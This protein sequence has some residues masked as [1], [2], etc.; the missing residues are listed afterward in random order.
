MATWVDNVHK[1]A[2]VLHD[3]IAVALQVQRD[4]GV[5][6]AAFIA[7]QRALLDEL[8]E[9]NMPLAGLMDKSDI[10]F[11]AEGPG[12]QH[13]AAFSNA[14]AWLCEEV[15]RR[16]RQLAVASL[17]LVGRAADAA[18]QDLRV[19]LNGMAPGSLWAGFSV[20]SK[21]RMASFSASHHGSKVP[22]MAQ[23]GDDEV[24]PQ[25]PELSLAMS[26]ALESVRAAV[27]ALPSIPQF[28]GEE[29][30][31]EEINDA[32]TDPLV[33]DATLIAAF[34]LAPTGRRG[35]HTLEI[36]APRSNEAQSSLTNRERTVLRETTVRQ[37][38]LRATKWG[39]FTGQLREVD[40]DARRFQ[41]RGVPNV[42]TVRCVL[43]AMNVDI[44]RRHIGQ[45]AKVTGSYE[46]DREGRPRLM[47]VDTIE[48]FQI[49]QEL[50]E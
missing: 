44:A 30:V 20:D 33:R 43:D 17:G 10:L 32:F 5:D 28:I 49:Q 27:R 13:H 11:H 21:Q 9:D 23:D 29:R 41:L 25:L 38:M 15:E 42:G 22:P 40:L 48:P 18:E 26:D 34:H 39:T 46:A 8:Y 7:Q 1:R 36:S 19:L 37:P 3:Q 45:G 14:V 47:R 24:A 50:D 16:L 2:A 35:I 12:A 31:S 6:M 4:K